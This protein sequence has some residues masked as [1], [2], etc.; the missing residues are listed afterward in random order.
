MFI[1]LSD[2]VGYVPGGTNIG[3]IRNDDSHVTLIDSGLNDTIARK[4]LRS[5]RDELGSEVVAILNTH[6]HADHFGANAFVVKRTGCEVWAPAI[7]ATTIQHPVM[8]PAMLFG[9]ADPMDA[10]RNRFLLAEASPLD[11]ELIAGKQRFMGTDIEL[12]ALPGHSPNQMGMLVDGV[13]FGAD[14]VFP[15]AAIE[16]YR[17][18]YLF[19][20]T[21]HLAS[22]DVALTIIASAVVP[23]HGPH[24]ESLDELVELNRET[25]ERTLDCIRDVLRTRATSDDICARVFTVL[26]VPVSDAQGYFLLK[27]T[28]NAYLAH[29]DRIGDV[30]CEIVDKRA[31]WSRR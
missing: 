30:L 2:R 27:P 23:G 4:V 6:G 10:L 13:F 21:D 20:L 29:L 16:K 11:G 5:V 14:V 24:A 19:G 12:V 28:I 7:E 3:V 18:P 1:P 22:L 25:I 9:G 17:L 15:R 31:L 8:Q 26:D